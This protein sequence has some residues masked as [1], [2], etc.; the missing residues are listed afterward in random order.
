[1]RDPTR[2]E[3]KR[4]QRSRVRMIVKSCNRKVAVRVGAFSWIRHGQIELTVRLKRPTWS[5]M[6][7]F[8]M[9]GR[10]K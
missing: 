10:K 7:T 2:H 4:W 6:K 1:M 9:I 3:R 5:A 8:G